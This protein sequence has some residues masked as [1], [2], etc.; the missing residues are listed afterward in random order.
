VAGAQFACFT[1]TKVQILTR[2]EALR[3]AGAQFTCFTGTKVQILTRRE[4]L[5]V[6]VWG[7]RVDVSDREVRQRFVELIEA[8]GVDLTGC[9]G[10]GGV[11][12]SGTK[13][14]RRGALFFLWLHVF[15]FGTYMCP[16]YYC[17]LLCMCPHANM[18]RCAVA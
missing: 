11:S 16:P 8:C 2:R 6:A 3:V 10:V 15:F 12:R 1:G 17:V 7:V 14:P 13:E 18:Y 9:G 5:R 4:A